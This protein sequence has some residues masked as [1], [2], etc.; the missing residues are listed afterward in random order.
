MVF[1]VR[2]FYIFEE[3]YKRKNESLK[4]LLFGYIEKRLIV[5]E[6]ND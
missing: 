6:G 2:M 4:Y 5:L 1:E 3:L